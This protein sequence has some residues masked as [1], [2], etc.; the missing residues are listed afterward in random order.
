MW[1]FFLPFNNL[2]LWI[3]GISEPGKGRKKE[4]KGGEGEEEAREE[5]NTCGALISVSLKLPAVFTV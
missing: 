3:S 5:G 4:K 2:S 1:H